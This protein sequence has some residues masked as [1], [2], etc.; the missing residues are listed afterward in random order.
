ML[1]LGLDI[2]TSITGYSLINTDLSQS[3]C[4]VEFDGIH[5]SKKKSLYEKADLIKKEFLSLSKSYKIDL[6]FAEE[7][8][9]SFRRGLSSAKTLSTL[10]RFNGVVCY[11]AEDIFNQE[12]HLTNVI[13]ARSSLGIKIDRKS[14]KTV[15]DQVLNWVRK[16]P[17]AQTI[18]WPTKKMK[19]GPR[20][21]LVIDDP[22]CFDIAD[23]CVMSM[24]GMKT[25]KA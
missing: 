9:Q 10:S 13:H 12:V 18:Q 17:E 7:S 11:L 25:L 15:K 16:Q 24:Y 20:K 4:V 2:S 1:V 3:D 8:L 6:I 22:S 19:S 23:A 21:G 5:L 14:D